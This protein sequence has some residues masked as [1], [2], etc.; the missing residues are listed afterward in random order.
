MTMDD[1]PR[2]GGGAPTDVKNS[3]RTHNRQ[4]FKYVTCVGTCRSVGEHT[5]VQLRGR[6]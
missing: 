1:D 4:I 2:H 5:L 3:E 6:Q